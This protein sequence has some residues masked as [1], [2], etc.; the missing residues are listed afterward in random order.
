[1]TS[2][3][4][5]PILVRMRYQ[6]DRKLSELAA[7]AAVV[8]RGGFSAAARIAGQRKATLSERV[9]DLEQRLDVK[10]I[11][12]STRTLRLTDEG[13]AFAEAAR[14]AL[15]AASDAETAVLEMRAK[16]SGTLRMSVSPPLAVALLEGVIASYVHQ[17]PDVV[18]EI[19]ASARTVDLVR[20]GF[21][22]AI[23][24]GRLA[25]SS[26]SVRRLGYARGGYYASRAY[27]ARE[28]VPEQPADLVHHDTIA[29]TRGD[30]MAKWHFVSGRRQRAVVV[31]P[32]VLVSSFELGIE[33][34]VAGLGVVPCTQHAVRAYV[35]KKQ[36]VPVLESWTPPI[37]EINAVFMSGGAVAPK[38]RKMID[39]LSAWFTA[40]GGRI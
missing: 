5:G 10:L 24:V 19:D 21:D 32:R 15:A 28:G 34:A 7:F 30:R 8:E 13:H 16:P 37:F 14:R 12:R 22:L 9:R 1:L 40:R 18:V 26:L 3:M 38:T 6:S 27:L 11:V 4:I 31:R 39:A 36:L 35:A 33:A 2:P 29:M 20:E 23:R 17:H 25:D